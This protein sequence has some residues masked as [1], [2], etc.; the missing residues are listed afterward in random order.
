MST[1]PIF[2]AFVLAAALAAPTAARAETPADGAPSFFGASRIASVKPYYAKSTLG[3]AAL[4][5]L[6]GAEVQLVPAPGLS[7]ERLGAQLERLLQFP[8]KW[9]PPP[10]LADVGHVHI[11]SDALGN[12]SAMQLIARD[13]SDAEQVF[14]RARRLVDE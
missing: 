9:P 7:S 12:A 5:P 6:R 11:E 10:W 1:R 14:R 8:R 2:A 3:R 13:P 4:R